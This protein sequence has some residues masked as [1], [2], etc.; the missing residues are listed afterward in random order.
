M[1]LSNHFCLGSAVFLSIFTLFSSPAS[2]IP[3]MVKV[4]SL[5]ANFCNADSIGSRGFC[6][7]VLSTPEAATVKDSTQLGVLIMKLGAAS[8]KST[9]NVYEKMVEKPCPPEA[10]RA[11][12]SCVEAYKY[13]IRSFKSVS[14]ELFEDPMT[15]NY[16]VAV[17]APIIEDCEKEL[18]EAKI[19]TPRLHLGNLVMQYYIAMGR[20]I[21]SIL[22]REKSGDY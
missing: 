7:K 18:T 12:N 10:L 20:E 22:Q 16:D 6:R 13:A 5:V 21:T 14:L 4:P 11:L 8:G 2:A 15:A 9:L 3:P 17:L 1:A 19:Q